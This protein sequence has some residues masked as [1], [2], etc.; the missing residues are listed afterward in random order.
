METIS[1]LQR[2]VVDWAR[3]KGWMD[4]EVPVPE[5]C[6]LIHSEVSEMLECWRNKEEIIWH[7]KNGKMCGIASE[8]ADI[9]IRCCHY[10]ELNGVDLENAIREKMFYNWSR[11]YRHGGKQG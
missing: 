9:V 7:D 1:D 3:A 6:A 2:S 4:R 8:L 10:A 5:Q 11:E